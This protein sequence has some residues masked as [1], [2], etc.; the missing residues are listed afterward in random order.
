[1]GFSCFYFYFY[2]IGVKRKGGIVFCIG[3]FVFCIYF[4]FLGLEGIILGFF[5]SCFTKLF[6]GVK[7]G[8][9]LC[10]YICEF[11]SVSG[12]FVLIKRKPVCKWRIIISMVMF[13]ELAGEY[14]PFVDN[15]I[16]FLDNCCKWRILSFSISWQLYYT[17]LIGH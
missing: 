16:I 12:M 14:F 8:G 4:V 5:I 1:M 11:S 3:V 7:N 9:E 15:C 10:W 17:V 6:G 13:I 2:F